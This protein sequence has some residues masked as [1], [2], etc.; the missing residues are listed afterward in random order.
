[1][2]RTKEILKNRS[3]YVTARVMETGQRRIAVTNLT[4]KLTATEKRVLALVSSAK[5]NKEIAS[6]LG[7]SPATVKRHLENVLRKLELKN[8]VEAAIYGLI[9][10]GCLTNQ[11]LLAR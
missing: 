7:I 1:M 2:R 8:R 6:A 9:A 10:S 11:I 3:E 5:T 4:S